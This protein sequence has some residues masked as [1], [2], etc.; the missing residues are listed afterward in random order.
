MYPNSF[1]SNSDKLRFIFKFIFF[2]MLIIIL[3]RIAGYSLE[4]YFKKTNF[5]NS[6]GKINKILKAESEILI[7]GSSRAQYHYVSNIIREKTGLSAYN[8]GID[9]HNALFDYV[10]QQLLFDHYIPDIIIYDYSYINIIKKEDPYECLTPLYPFYKNEKV[11]QL[12]IRKNWAEKYRFLSKIFPYNSKIHS[13]LKYNIFPPSD[14]H[15]GYVPTHIKMNHSGK[16]PLGGGTTVYDEILVDAVI[17]LIESG[18]DH[19]VRVVL[20]MSPRYSYGTYFVPEK[21]QQTIEKYHTPV[22]NFRLKEYPDFS[23]Q[24]YFRDPLHLNNE[25]AVLFTKE[26]CENINDIIH[27]PIHLSAE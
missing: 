21:L 13:I 24:K 1:I 7:F 4:Y 25:G 20:C 27:R 26:L 22:I 3:D 5:G 11:H 12:I 2:L 16:I 8:A 18:S 6:G 17:K 23:D 19:N 10:L 9:G 14:T 15:N